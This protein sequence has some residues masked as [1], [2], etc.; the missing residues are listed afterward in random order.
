MG[1]RNIFHLEARSARRIAAFASTALGAM[2]LDTS[3]ATAEWFSAERPPN[4]ILVYTADRDGAGAVLSVEC[5]GGE[6]SVTI[7]WPQRLAGH[8][9]QVVTY[10][11][12]SQRP[13]SEQWRLSTDQLSVG[14]WGRNAIPLALRLVG[15]NK[16]TIR[17]TSVRGLLATA[18]FDISG[19]DRAVTRVAEVCRWR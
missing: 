13:R 18:Q 4:S 5:K 15:K 19:L 7:H 10:T 14:V 17:A 8:Y 1:G 16:L 12:D 11:I 2:A 3:M 9:A 6:T